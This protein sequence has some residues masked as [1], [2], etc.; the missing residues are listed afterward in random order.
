MLGGVVG[1]AA[2]TGLIRQNHGMSDTGSVAVV[3]HS[4]RPIRYRLTARWTVGGA[5]Q[6]TRTRP[7]SRPTRRQP[8]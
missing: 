1:K 7:R 8:R 5:D 4:S 6:P 2:D 3:A